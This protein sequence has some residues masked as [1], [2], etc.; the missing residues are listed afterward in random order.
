MIDSARHHIVRVEHSESRGVPS[1]WVTCSC[2]TETAG[3]ARLG[4][5]EAFASHLDLLENSPLWA[6]LDRDGL[7]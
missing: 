7:L 1:V 3:L 4:A 5:A 2:G 6:A